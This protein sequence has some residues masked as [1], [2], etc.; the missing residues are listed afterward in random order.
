MRCCN[1]A[2]WEI[3]EVAPADAGWCAAKRRP[4]CLPNAG[5]CLRGVAPAPE[6]KMCCGQMEEVRRL[7]R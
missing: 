5:P 6:G 4:T 1:R 3:R 2:Q 7:Y